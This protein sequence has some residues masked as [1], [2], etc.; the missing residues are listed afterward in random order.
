M[1]PS[2]PIPKIMPL[3]WLKGFSVCVDAAIV[4]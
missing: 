3:R 1:V 2:D 4:S